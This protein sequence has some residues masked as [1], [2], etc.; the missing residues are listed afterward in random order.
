MKKQSM[1]LLG[2]TLAMLLAGCARGEVVTELSRTGSAN[3]ECR[4][5]AVPVVAS[6]LGSV[7]ED[8]V[9]DGFQ[10]E[11][12]TEEKMKGFVARRHFEKI[13]DV[14]K[15]KLLG[16]SGSRAKKEEPKQ[17][18]EP[19]SAQKTKAFEYK[20]GLLFDTVAVKANLDL[21][22]KPG[23][24]P[25]DAQWLFK[26]LLQQVKLRFVLKL[27]TAAESSNAGL[28]ADGGK[29]LVWDLV[30]GENNLLEARLTYLNPYKA[31]A[32]SAIL[33]AAAI[34]F[35]LSRRRKK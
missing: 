12:V 11:D 26:N 30:F 25:G 4:V 1:L 22:H 35:M 28:V 8:F 20:H 31:G 18:E 23:Q 32:L 9:A 6:Q 15:I 17:I 19:A 13:N 27:P 29:T 3:I 7:K 34:F 16:G 5:V 21:R 14:N 10:V 2:L 33:L 24:D